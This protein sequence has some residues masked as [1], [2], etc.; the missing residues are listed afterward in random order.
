[1]PA[2]LDALAFY[3]TACGFVFGLG[4]LPLIPFERQL[5]IGERAAIG[6]AI[7]LALASFLL[8][9]LTIAHAARAFPPIAFAA[10]A[11]M[12]VRWCRLR[13]LAP[14]AR[15]D[16]ALCA[17]VAIVVFT[18]AAWTSAGRI[19]TTGET[20]SIYGDYETFDLTYYAAIASEL[21]H[22]TTIPP[23]SPFYAGHRIIYSYFSLIFLAA[24]HRVS[25]VSLLQAFLAYGWPFYTGVAAA[26]VFALCRRLGSAVFATVTS[27]LV[28]TGSSLAYIAWWWSPDIVHYDPLIWSSLFLAPPG[29][30]VYFNP[31]APA[32]AATAAGLYA[33]TF[34]GEPRWTWWAT[35]AGFCFGAL[36]MFKSFSSPVTIAALAATVAV[37][38]LRRDPTAP[39]V[40]AVL[41]AALAWSAPWL[42]VILP[43]NQ[44]ENRGAQVTVEYFW[45]VRRMLLKADWT[46]AIEGVLQRWLRLPANA[47]AI[48]TVATIAFLI[49]GMGPRLLGLAPWW[50]AAIGRA[51]MRGWTPVAWIAVIGVGL[52]FV[53]TI[54]PFPNAIQTYMFALFM[55]WPFAVHAVWPPAAPTTTGRWAATMLLVCLSVPSTLHY[56]RAAHDAATGAPITTIDEGDAKIVRYLRRTNADT[57]MMLHSNPVWPSLYVIEA[58]RRTVLAWSSYV[59]GD[60]NPEVDAL[61]AE[62]ARFFG[63]PQSSGADDVTILKR[64][65]VT[66]VIE[67]MSTDRIHPNVVRRLRL[68]TGTPAV[69]LYEVPPDLLP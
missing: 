17:S 61:R 53:I 34:L 12:L 25:G 5:P 2:P 54:A 10:T 22:T 19:K 48:L 14:S 64:F 50:R 66:H 18:I 63:T 29:E 35:I 4:T 20:V 42:V 58:E 47:Y 26:A 56:V 55:M 16:A 24:V 28:F 32:L 27:L 45:L 13:R 21:A 57:T 44:A 39:R 68:V 69:R 33:L 65:R 30:W 3:L 8:C 60:G 31:W 6:C 62:V 23:L 36:F 11:F 67:R 7:G 51:D 41:G 37:L 38:W 40:A 43:Y 52:S 9:L 46:P 1:M 49:G 15:C 59:E